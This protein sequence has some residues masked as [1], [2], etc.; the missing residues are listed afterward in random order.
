[1]IKF[2]SSLFSI[3]FLVVLILGMG[4]GVSFGNDTLVAADGIGTI[5][6]PDSS[7]TPCDATW[8][9]DF[10]LNIPIMSFGQ[11]FYQTG[12]QYSPSSD[13]LIWFMLTGITQIAP[14]G[15]GNP[16]TLILSD[17]K[18]I[19]HI[20]SLDLGGTSL[21]LDLE[22]VPTADGLIWLKL[23]NYAIN[24]STSSVT[25]LSKVQDQFHTTFN[26]YS[27]AYAAGNHFAARGM[28]NSAP[29]MQENWSIA[30]HSGSTCIRCEFKSSTSPWGGWY[31]MNGVLQ[32]TASSPSENWGDT[33]NAG[34]DLSGATQITFWAK[35]D[36]GGERA[37][38]FALGI[39]RNSSTGLAEK[40]YP[41]SSPKAS[42][43]VVTLSNDWQKFTISLVGRDLGYV[44][45]G[46]GWVA[47]ATENGQHDI[48]F[49]LDDITYD[50][51]RSSEPRFLVSY[52]TEPGTN[53]FDLIMRNVAYTYDNA[54]ALI[55]LLGASENNRAKL[56]ADAFVYAQNNDR[57]FT[58]GRLRNAYQG[59]DIS[60]PP[61][62]YP[63]GK[64]GTVRM[65]GWSD[66]ST[67]NWIEDANQVGS[68][69]GNMAWA[70]LSLLAYYDVT[71]DNTYLSSVIKMADW[72]EVNC[73]DTRGAGGY[74]AGF[75]GW[76]PN[77]NQ[78]VQKQQKYKSTEH[79]ID[80]FAVFQRLFTIT[81]DTKW[82][83]RAQAAKQFVVA[84]W[85]DSQAPGKFWT[86]TGDDGVTINKTQYQLPLDVQAWAVLSLKD[87]GIPYW[88]ALSYAEQNMLVLNADKTEPLGF[89]FNNDLDGVWYEGTAQMTEA[90]RYI[91]QQANADKFL[92]ILK[93]S[94]LSTG[95]M[96]ATNK[97]TITTGFQL[98]DGSDWLYYQRP[99]VGATSWLLLA[100]KGVNPYYWPGF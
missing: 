72:V 45:G 25:Y 61:G 89:D 16:A 63:N 59:G 43:G 67:N 21:W 60:L 1:M 86:G 100:E 30:Q 39:G 56:I 93:S 24:G 65:P 64:I 98:S 87:E 29:V 35:G 14:N 99:H 80:L 90:F 28:L 11:N 51:N 74:S 7:S 69:T 41:D 48:V 84:M 12:F 27:D 50:K 22:Y 36:K 57:Y 94:Q 33:P 82:R 96:P 71:E 5:L 76:E 18:Y 42:S 53:S 3:V 92:S 44:L 88:S 32:G 46:F 9:S 68:D 15:C 23:T 13:G 52:E 70:M 47:A 73:R 17:G 19:L 38:F 95:A 31:M 2:C 66:P 85:D 34:M 75:Y 77:P 8:S 4:Y 37:E 83:D 78:P 97:D 55:S 49:Y 40:P 20:P 58:D 81:G 79:N 54:V 10:T 62:W 91:G 6:Q 26:V